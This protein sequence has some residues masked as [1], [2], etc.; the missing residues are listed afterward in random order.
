MSLS[1]YY[2]TLTKVVIT[3]VPDGGG[4]F[5]ETETTSTFRGYVA[6]MNA[7]EQVMSAQRKQFAVA[8]LFT[9]ETLIAENK[10]RK[11]TIEYEIVGVYDFFHKFYDLKQVK[12]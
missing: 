2:E 3:L 9:K 5:T 4:Q 8:K 11:G 7:Y 1:D 10:I 6:L 12:S